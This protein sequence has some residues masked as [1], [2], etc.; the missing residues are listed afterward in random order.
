D[1]ALKPEAEPTGFPP[2]W[3]PSSWTFGAFDA[4]LGQGNLPR[5]FFNSILTSAVITATT[6]VTASLVAFG[7]SRIPYRGRMNVFWLIMAGIMVPVEALV[8][9]LFY[10]VN[11]MGLVNTYWA[12]IL[13]QIASPVAVFIFKQFF[14]GIPRELEEA[15]IMH[16][17][18]RFRIY[19]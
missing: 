2:R 10:E 18:G 1:T 6:V 11:S 14:V 5:W 15:A 17:A 13:P 7:L 19:W 3:I 12:I 8:V 9:P 4:V 16:G